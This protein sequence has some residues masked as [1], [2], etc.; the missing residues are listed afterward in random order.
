MEFPKKY[1]LLEIQTPA[2]CTAA[3]GADHYAMPHPQL[4]Y[5]FFVF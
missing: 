1:G 3:I 4:L 5:L 2:S